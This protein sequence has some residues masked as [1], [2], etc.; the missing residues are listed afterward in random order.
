MTT[1]VLFCFVFFAWNLGYLKVQIC[2]KQNQHLSPQ[3][4]VNFRLFFFCRIHL[5]P[6]CTGTFLPNT[7][8]TSLYRY[9]VY[10]YTRDNGR[11]S[12]APVDDRNNNS[13]ILGT[14]SSRHPP[15]CFHTAPTRLKEANLEGSLGRTHSTCTKKQGIIVG[16]KH[17]AGAVGQCCSPQQEPT[18]SSKG[19]GL[20]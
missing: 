18:K 11:R 7:P 4:G 8:W 5:E 14:T 2:I 17:A 15:T 10:P 3:N 16:C 13:G 19:S 12:S 9:T 20:L 1:G 6:V